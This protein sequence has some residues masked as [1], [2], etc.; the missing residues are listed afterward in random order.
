MAHLSLLLSARRPLCQQRREQFTNNAWA[1]YGV[2]EALNAQC[3]ESATTRIDR[4]L[5]IAWVGS[6]DDLSLWRL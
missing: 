5:D 3:K 2:R 6:R 1:L 4:R